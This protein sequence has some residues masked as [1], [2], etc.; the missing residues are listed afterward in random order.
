MLPGMDGTG[1]LFAPL[2]ARLGPAINTVVVRYPDEPLGYD[3]LTAHARQALPA[4]GDF[5][6]LG[7]SFSGPVA[8][9]LAAE[10]PSGLRGLILSATFVRNPLPWTAPFVPL[11]RVLP[12]TGAMASLLTH[13]LLRS[14]STPALRAGIAAS[15][16]QVSPATIRARLRAIA[17]VDVSKEL[18]AVGVPITYLRAEHDLVVPR[19]ACRLINHIAPH[20]RTVSIHAPHFLLQAS[21]EDG[22]CAIC[23][24]MNDITAR[25]A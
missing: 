14:F 7:E 6:L 15:L 23:A 21:V 8:I 22:A 20:T 1:D 19:A 4:S 18:A 3:A 5:F 13:V 16:A 25:S 10:Q 9:A 17:A 2:I 12:V 11:L 24:S